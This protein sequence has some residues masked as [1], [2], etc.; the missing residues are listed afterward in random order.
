ML[1]GPFEALENMAT[2]LEKLPNHE[3]PLEGN[4]KALRG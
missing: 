2:Y 4:Q 1:A 3:T